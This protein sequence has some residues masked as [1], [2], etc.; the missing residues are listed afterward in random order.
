MEKN[1]ISNKHPN[2]V[3]LVLARKNQ[4]NK[5][6]ELK[7]INKTNNQNKTINNEQ[8]KIGFEQAKAL[9]T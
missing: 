3:L 8:L 9:E 1:R 7:Q 2:S 5:R 6:W 4:T